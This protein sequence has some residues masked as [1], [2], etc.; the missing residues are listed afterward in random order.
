MTRTCAGCC[1][2]FHGRTD[3]KFCSPVCRQR[4]HR[5]RH[6]RYT[7]EPVLDVDLCAKMSDPKR[8]RTALNLVNYD[9]HRSAD[10]LHDT[11][12]EP[13]RAD[14]WADWIDDC[15][16]WLLVVRDGLRGM[17]IDQRAQATVARCARRG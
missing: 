3:A 1:A 2:E 10:E 14:E 11:L 16:E 5:D 9:A 12:S 4:A 13:N 7:P 8:L 6:R 17:D 15:I